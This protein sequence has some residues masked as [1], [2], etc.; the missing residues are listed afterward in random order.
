MIH[1][2]PETF[3]FDATKGRARTKV[4]KLDATPRVVLVPGVGLFSV[5]RT[6]ADARI[7]ADIA[8]HTIVAKAPFSTE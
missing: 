3:A 5:G 7:A 2:Q 4:T 8:D 1:E 6:K